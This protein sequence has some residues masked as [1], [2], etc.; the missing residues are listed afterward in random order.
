[1]AA[2]WAAVRY[3]G[4]VLYRE[5]VWTASSALWCGRCNKGHSPAAGPVMY[6]CRIG[7]PASLPCALH[8]FSMIRGS[9]RLYRSLAPGLPRVPCVLCQCC[10]S[11]LMLAIHCCLCKVLLWHLAHVVAGV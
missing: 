2:A 3:P 7:Q 8:V 9:V 10:I 4:R 1:M 11:V 6:Q 5:T